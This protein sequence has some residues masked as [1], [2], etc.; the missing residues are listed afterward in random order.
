MNIINFQPL[1]SIIIPSF[2]RADIFSYTLDSIL[3]QTYSN[4][5]C[6]IVDDGSTDETFSLIESYSKRD[7]RIKGTKRPLSKPK[8]AN[9]CRNFGLSKA[10][11][12]Y[13]IFFDSDDHMA[14]NCLEQRVN[15]FKK[16][17]DKDFLV[18]SMGIFR[19]KNAFEIPPYRKVVNLPLKEIIKDFILSVSLPWNVCRPIYKTDFIKDKI[20]FNEKIQNFQD[21]EFHIRLLSELKPNYLSIDLTDCYYRYDEESLNKY[22]SL[23][24]HQNIVNCFNE[25][26]TTVF[27]A[28]TAE[29]KLKLNKELKLKFF[30]QVSFYVIP[31]INREVLFESIKLFEKELGFKFKEKLIFNLLLFLNKYYYQR[32]GYYIIKKELKKIYKTITL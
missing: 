12:I 29:Q 22:N 16:H 31:R 19:K 30:T 8:G 13:C 4:W 32:K 18:F 23:N 3:S 14:T 10:N 1:V 15:L 24:G 5:E 21:D 28:L 26:Y 7:P 9:A 20:E 6:I 11:G 17:E 25:Y 2:N 27:K